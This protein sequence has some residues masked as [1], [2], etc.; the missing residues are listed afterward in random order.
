LSI[1]WANTATSTL[2]FIGI[3]E[4]VRFHADLHRTPG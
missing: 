4:Y 2:D 3:K 1:C